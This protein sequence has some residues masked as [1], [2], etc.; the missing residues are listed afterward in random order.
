MYHKASECRVMS[1]IHINMD[2]HSHVD[3]ATFNWYLTV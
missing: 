1:C 2:L 3:C